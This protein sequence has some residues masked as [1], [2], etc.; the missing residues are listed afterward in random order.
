MSWAVEKD[1]KYS[2][3]FL[4]YS[5]IFLL[6][7]SNRRNCSSLTLHP[8]DTKLQNSLLRIWYNFNTF[9]G[10]CHTLQ[11]CHH[12][13]DLIPLEC[14]W[15]RVDPHQ[16][17]NWMLKVKLPPVLHMQRKVFQTCPTVHTRDNMSQPSEQ[18]IFIFVM[19]EI[20]ES[21]LFRVIQE[22]TKGTCLWS[23]RE[24]YEDM[25]MCEELVDLIRSMT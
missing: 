19:P 4:C 16:S 13:P 20:S 7:Q 24:E 3:N 10:S 5:T 12:S 6:C 1:V 14:Y 21:T 8:A 22:Y 9:E 23:C 17:G 15:E 18:I 11:W 2:A 25:K